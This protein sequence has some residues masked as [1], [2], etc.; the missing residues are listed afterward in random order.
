MNCPHCHAPQPAQAHTCST[1]H[2]TYTDQDLLHLR[3]LEFLLDATESWPGVETQ[4]SGYAQELTSLRAKFLPSQST[5]DQPLPPVSTEPASQTQKPAAAPILPTLEP[6]AK[7]VGQTIANTAASFGQWLFSEGLI[8][9]A[10]YSGGFLLVL[11][12][13]I[14]I[15]ATWSIMPGLLKLSIT[16]AFTGVMYGAGALLFRSQRLRIGG[17]ALLAVA[18]GFAPLN[19]V[20]LHVYLLRDLGINVNLTWLLAS[21]VCLFFYLVTTFWTR[22]Q[23]FT[24]FSALT[25]VS[26]VLALF[27]L[28]DSWTQLSWLPTLAWLALALLAGAFYGSAI[29]LRSRP[30]LDFVYW[31]LLITAHLLTPLMFLLN[32]ANW[33]LAESRFESVL[34]LMAMLIGAGFYLADSFVYRHGWARWAASAMFAL[35]TSFMVIELDLSFYATTALLTGLALIYL[36]LGWQVTRLVESARAG[37]PLYLAGYALAALVMMTVAVAWLIDETSLQ[38]LSLVLLLDVLMLLASTFIHRHLIWLY[39]AVWLFIAPVASYTQVFWPGATHVG[40]VLAGLMLIY[41]GGAVGLAQLRAGLRWPF[42]TAAAVLSG[43]VVLLTLEEAALVTGMLIFIAGLYL[44]MAVWLRWPWLLFATLAAINLAIITGWNATEFELTAG[45]FSVSYGFLGLLL[46]GLAVGLRQLEWT[47]ERNSQSDISSSLE[48]S[49][50]VVSHLNHWAWPVYLFAAIDL[51]G[52]YGL[53]LIADAP[54]AWA[55]SFGL[56]AVVLTLSWL[57]RDLMLQSIKLPTAPTSYAGLLLIFI[58]HL[59]LLNDILDPSTANIWVASS[60]ILCGLY[61]LASWACRS[62]ETIRRLYGEPLHWSG[63]GLNLIPLVG[64]S[65]VELKLAGAASLVIIGL[66]LS[67]DGLARRW[68][69]QAYLGSGAFVGALWYVLGYFAVTEAQAYIIPAGL[70]LV[71]LSLIEH[72]RGLRIPYLLLML[73]G[74]ALLLGSAFLQSFQSWSYALLLMVES[75][76][77][78]GGGIALRS[79]GLVELAL[80]A[81]F[82]DALVQFGAAFIEMPRFIQIGLI[83]TTLF[84]GGLLLLIF[85]E[86]LLSAHRQWRER[87]QF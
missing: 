7:P 27:G 42:L 55:Y 45:R 38:N 37:W 63:L 54:L 12:G 46:T 33:G 5:L 2:F 81:L 9:L 61:L 59:Y 69:Y 21:F 74:L 71:S 70:W 83:G 60:A 50:T 13:L 35:T 1:C 47:R 29:L 84:G 34:A 86:R 22:T 52:G 66:S 53:S 49:T 10:L 79:R 64:L 82:A 67:L 30:G 40:L 77:V 80:L 28:L 41:V 4:R 62:N 20:V 73:S 58:G 75:I 51:V 19:F 65:G 76:L 87:W 26:T 15:G 6:A 16:G 72:Y 8:K 31:P 56:A 11:A 85:R 78:L 44:A 23:L 25:V 32:A 18:G 36:I 48:T 3:Q 14:F 43:L 17:V 68:I 39:G 24:Y 57:E